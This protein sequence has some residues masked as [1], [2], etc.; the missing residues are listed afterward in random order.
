MHT[1]VIIDMQAS[2]K[3]SNNLRLTRSIFREIDLSKRHNW[4]I[5]I[6]EY[7]NHGHTHRNIINRI[8]RY[9][10]KKIS[11][12]TIDDGSFEANT[13]IC[14][15]TKCRRVR[16]VGVNLNACVIDTARGLKG[17]GYKVE[18][19]NDACRSD[20]FWFHEWQNGFLQV[21]KDSDISVIRHKVKIYNSNVW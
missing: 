18:I 9:S 15:L 13:K 3:S 16:L 7:K 11:T 10:K 4:P 2:F 21:I 17:L 5:V 20:G 6:L 1:L 8:G 14:N 19:V 12:K